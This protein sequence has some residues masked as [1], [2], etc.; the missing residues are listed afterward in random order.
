MA[1]GKWGGEACDVRRRIIWEDGE[2][3]D[4]GGRE[5]MSHRWVLRGVVGIL[6]ALG[7]AVGTVT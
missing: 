3:S 2:G 5:E 7:L 6:E 4:S 1:E